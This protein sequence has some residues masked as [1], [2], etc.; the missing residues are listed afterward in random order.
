MNHRSVI[1]LLVS[2]ALAIAAC[3]DDPAEE[4]SS[5]QPSAAEVDPAS[6]WQEYYDVTHPA[7]RVLPASPWE[8][9]YDLTH[10]AP[11]AD[12]VSGWEVYYDLTHPAP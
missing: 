4:P 10:P 7:P 5:G 2:G 1:A 11:G 8:V 12:A 6:A 3:G 9:Y